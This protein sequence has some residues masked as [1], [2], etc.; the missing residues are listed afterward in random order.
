MMETFLTFFIFS[1]IRTSLFF[2]KDTFI[3]FISAS[4]SFIPPLHIFLLSLP[5]PFSLT[6]SPFSFYAFP[7]SLLF[8]F[9]PFI[10][11]NFTLFFFFPSPL[12]LFFIFLLSTFLYVFS[13]FS[14]PFPFFLKNTYSLLYSS[15]FG[16]SFY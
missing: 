1:F 3:S 13:F 16:F 5:F 15:F 10:I 14:L 4:L 7:L 2:Y 12:S 8:F 6:L 9:S 11:Y